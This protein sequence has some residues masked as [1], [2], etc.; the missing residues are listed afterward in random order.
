M[1]IDGKLIAEDLRRDL[2]ARVKKTGRRLTLGV[3]AIDHSAATRQ[4]LNIKQKFGQSIGVTVNVLSLP[5][6]QENTEHLLAL[7]LHAAKSCDG[8]ILQLPLPGTFDTGQALSLFPLPLDVDVIGATAY[9]QF[10]EGTLPFFPPVI[11]AFAEVLHRH[12]YTLAGKEVVVVGEGRLVGAPAAVWARRMGGNVTVANR[13]TGDLA[14]LTRNADV[15]ILGAGSPGLL[16][17]DMVK[18][19]VIVLDAGTSEEGGVVKGDADP[20]VGTIAAL[21][22]PTPGGVGPLTVAKVFE[23]LLILDGIKHPHKDA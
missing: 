9:R 16:T 3:V 18:Q 15:V 10:E 5:P 1:L 6:F 8:L 20:A 21:F 7:I 2:A 23:N 11:A 22:T 17:P 13:S 19:G 12:H 4:F 14:A